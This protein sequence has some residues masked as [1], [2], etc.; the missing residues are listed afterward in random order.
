MDNLEKAKQLLRQEIKSARDGNN[1]ICD[2]CD[3]MKFTAHL[4]FLLT[5]GAE[6]K[7]SDFLNNCVE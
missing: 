1:Y 2:A 6:G 5:D 3:G 7:K 4:L